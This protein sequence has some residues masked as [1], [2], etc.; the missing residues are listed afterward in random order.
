MKECIDCREDW[1]CFTLSVLKTSLTLCAKQSKV[2]EAFIEA[3]VRTWLG[4]S[5]GRRFDVIASLWC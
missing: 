3:F 5:R 1:Y 2:Q 4:G